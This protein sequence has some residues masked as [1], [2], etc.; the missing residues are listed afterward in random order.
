MLIGNTYVLPSSSDPGS[1]GFGYNWYQSDTGNIYVRNTGNTAWVIVGNANQT[2]LGQLSRAGG[3]MTGAILGASGLMPTSGGDFT[4]APTILGDAI[5][6]VPYVNTQMDT[7]RSQL[8]V[9]VAQAIASIPSLSV[10][11]KL[12]IGIGSSGPLTMTGT[13]TITGSYTLP[14]PTY[15]D[16]TTASQSEVTG[17]YWGWIQDWSAT[18]NAVGAA[19]S[20]WTVTE[21]PANSRIMVVTSTSDSG[22]APQGTPWALGYIII[23]IKS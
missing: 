19:H 22:V 2:Y 17:R 1:V 20:S 13:P 14:L 12:A 7:L 15:G 9:Q 11:S 3:T 5:A 16:G 6:T 10:S 21:S 23:G 18:D 8:N 4:V